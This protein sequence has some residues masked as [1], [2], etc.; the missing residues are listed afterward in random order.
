MAF[1][2]FNIHSMVSIMPQI[3]KPTINMAGM[4]QA[5]QRTHHQDHDMMWHNFKTM[6]TI[7]R[8][9]VNVMPPVAP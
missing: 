1:S 4:I 7:V 8:R 6:N 3:I 5:G 2:F 9:P